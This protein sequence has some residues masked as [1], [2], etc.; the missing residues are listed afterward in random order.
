[1]I[2]SLRVG[3]RKILL[4]VVREVVKTHRIFFLIDGLDEIDGETDEA[5]ELALDLARLL[6]VK[7]CT[8]SRPWPVFEDAFCQK[9]NLTMQK[10][11]QSDIKSYVEDGLGQSNGFLRLQK[12]HRD[13]ASGLID[14]V[15]Q[16]SAGVFLWVALVVK[17]LQR[18]LREDDRMVDLQQRIDELPNDLETLFT[19][20]IDSLDNKKLHRAR[21]YFGLLALHQHQYPD[22]DLTALALSFADEERLSFFISMPLGHLSDDEVDIRVGTMARRVESASRGLLEVVKSSSQRKSKVDYLHRTVVE[23]FKSDTLKDL[24]A[25]KASIQKLPSDGFQKYLSR[26]LLFAAQADE[27][28]PEE[29]VRHAQI[30]EVLYQ[31]DLVGEELARFSATIPGKYTTAFSKIL[32]A[33]FESGH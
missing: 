4:N 3:E 26:I 5:A 9:P 33:T 11:T 20:I 13:Y 31:A 2:Q 6:N 24:P 32:E 10:L 14:Q 23:Y 19:R 18:G 1:M 17:S 16:K 28:L 22:Q 27:K 21:Q 30:A 29:D 7:V 25:S 12:Q 8:S 15:A